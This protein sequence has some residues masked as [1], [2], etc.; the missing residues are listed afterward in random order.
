LHT[1]EAG[2]FR[3]YTGVFD[4]FRVFCGQRPQETAAVLQDRADL[5]LGSTAG[6][7]LRNFLCNKKT[8]AQGCRPKYGIFY[9]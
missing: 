5:S 6:I 1:P 2:V 9:I 7:D 8:A 3:V 4:L